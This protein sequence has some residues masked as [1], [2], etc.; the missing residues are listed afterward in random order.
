MKTNVE[1]VLYNIEQAELD[2]RSIEAKDELRKRL[3]ELT[4]DRSV[5]LVVFNC[6]DFSWIQQRKN[7]YPKSF[8]STDPKLSI[9]RYYQDYIGVIRSELADLGKPDL[10]VII[11][12]SELLDER[13]FS[14]AQSR[15]ERLNLALSSKTALVAELTALNNPNSPVV[16]WSEYCKEQNLKLPLDYTAENYQRIQAE[17]Q[18][19]T[20]V[21][22]Q[23]K[24]SRRY[25]KKNNIDVSEV[26]DGEFTDRITWYLAMYMGEGQALRDSRA[27]C[28]NLEDGRVPAWFQRGAKGLQPILNLVDP[29][30]FYAWRAKIT[31]GQKM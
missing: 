8:V 25:F 9:C 3:E 6:L 19:Q 22:D 16:L 30:E 23:V 10:K 1:C 7:Q 24:D 27:I 5:P 31:G 17:S 2:K 15:S 13:V 29:R 11:P 28:L 20:R 4:E 14:F 12:D 21:K 26:C 18:L